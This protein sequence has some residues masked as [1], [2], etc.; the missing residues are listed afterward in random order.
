MNF[1][2]WLMINVICI[3]CKRLGW[4]IA[5]GRSDDGVNVTDI[6]IGPSKE[7]D[8]ICDLLEPEPPRER[9]EG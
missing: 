8:K 1:W 4:Q 3:C 9:N 6:I 2:T 7:V 5:V